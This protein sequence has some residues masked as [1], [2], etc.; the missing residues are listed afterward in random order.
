MEK[1]EGVKKEKTSSFYC[2]RLMETGH[3]EGQDED[4]REPGTGAEE[5]YNCLCP[6]PQ[7]LNEDV[8]SLTCRGS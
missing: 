2:D 3:R 8:G 7:P 6:G 4:A 5:G 1:L